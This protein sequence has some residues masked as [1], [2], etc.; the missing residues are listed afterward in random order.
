MFQTSASN[1]KTIKNILL[2]KKWRW[3]VHRAEKPFRILSNG[4]LLSSFT[5]NSTDCTTQRSPPSQT[6]C[7]DFIPPRCRATPHPGEQVGESR[8]AHD[9]A[10]PPA[11]KNDRLSH[12]KSNYWLHHALH[13]NWINRHQ[14]QIA[15]K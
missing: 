15:G 14:V 12:F 4:M 13:L 11:S 10:C 9:K 1:R 5:T 7:M 2:S 3:P 8:T 6:T